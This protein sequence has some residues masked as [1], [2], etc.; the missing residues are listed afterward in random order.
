MQNFIF[1][2]Y[3]GF[4]ACIHMLMMKHVS[5]EKSVCDEAAIVVVTQDIHTHT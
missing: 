3:T 5:I 1:G 2:I 4:S